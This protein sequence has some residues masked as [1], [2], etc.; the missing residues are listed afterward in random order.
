MHLLGGLELCAASFDAE[1][2]VEE[3]AMEVLDDAVRLR[4][5][6][7]GLAVLD[8]LKLQEQLVG[9][10]IGPAAELAAVVGEHGLD[11]D[12]VRLE[13]GQQVGV[14]QMTGILLVYKRALP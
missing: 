10:T 8:A 7:A 14:E 9:M 6:D 2:L 12:A 1:V 11:L 5:L 13:G 4:A 3:G